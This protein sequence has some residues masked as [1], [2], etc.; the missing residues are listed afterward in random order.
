MITSLIMTYHKQR[1]LSGWH[2]KQKQVSMVWYNIQLPVRC[3]TFTFLVTKNVW[4]FQNLQSYKKRG[5]NIEKTN[6]IS[7]FL[8]NF[9]KVTIKVCNLNKLVNFYAFLHSYWNIILSIKVPIKFV[10]SESQIG[11]IDWIMIN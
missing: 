10:I 2:I 11:Y 7:T 8:I 3:F 6:L 9:K 1:I 4:Q 5:R